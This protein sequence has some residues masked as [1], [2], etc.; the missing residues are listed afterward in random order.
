MSDK[1]NFFPALRM[2]RNPPKTKGYAMFS[3]IHAADIHIDSP[4]HK[5]D[6]YDGA[7]VE[8]FRLSTRKALENIVDRAAA[9]KADFVLISGDLYD[10][11]WKD[12]N[13]GLYFVA[14]MN[15]LREAGI[16]VFIAAG[17]HD[18]ASAITKSL[19]LPDNV[20][21]FGAARAETLL[22]EELPVAIHGR[23]FASP[24]EK[25]DLSRDYPDPVPG[26]FNIGMLHTAL[27][28]RPGHEPYAPCSL[29][30]LREKGY[31]YWALGHVHEY[32]VLCDDPFIVFPGNT[33]G[34]HVREPGPRGCLLVT[35]GEDM[36]IAPEFIATDVVR[37]FTLTIDA[38]EAQSPYDV[39]DAFAGRLEALLSENESMPLAVRV[40]ITGET[41][42]AADLSA[43]PDRWTGEIRAAA[44]TSGGGRVWVEKV[45]F[46][47]R[48][49]QAAHQER[50]GGAME[51]LLVLFDELADDPDARMA[52]AGAL[53]DFH[54]RLPPEVRDGPDGIRL[55][56]SDWVGEMI[57]QV[58]PELVGRLMRKGG[59]DA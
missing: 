26:R 25:K 1:P 51:E 35:V 58:R 18:A 37:W 59:G 15:R 41:P 8:A 56:D 40:E 5:L 55:D 7:P 54:R 32:E 24:A 42:A 14:Q 38:G 11:D 12:Y 53:S 3:F 57:E 19:R 39:V 50:M 52:M 21:L 6:A 34:R 27:T 47:C 46:S 49:P 33:Q 29:S 44:M 45:Q 31:H 17:N 20:T 4:M 16:P 9:D 28:G 2:C 48:L 22:L 43:D 36:G 10:G 30:G 23:S 13:T